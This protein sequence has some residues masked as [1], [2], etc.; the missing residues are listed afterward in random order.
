MVGEPNGV[1]D[2]FQDP[3]SS[4]DLRDFLF[5]STSSNRL[6]FFYLITNC[7]LVSD[8]YC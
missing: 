5:V 2:F 6:Q 8:N 7:K 4:N 1:E 3:V